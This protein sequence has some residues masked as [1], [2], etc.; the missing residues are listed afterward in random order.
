MQDGEGRKKE[1]MDTQKKMVLAATS[2]PE[3]CIRRAQVMIVTDMTWHL[4]GPGNLRAHGLSRDIP[5][6]TVTCPVVDVSKVR[7]DEKM[8]A[9]IRTC[10]TPTAGVINMAGLLTGLEALGGNVKSSGQ[11][12]VVSVQKAV[13][14][15][16][17]KVIRARRGVR[18]TVRVQ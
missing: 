18:G 9:I 14:R 3:D 12:T 15:E 7:D 10:V 6:P 8:G 11:K 5:Q 4:I 2:V 1:A 16:P 13:S 17:V